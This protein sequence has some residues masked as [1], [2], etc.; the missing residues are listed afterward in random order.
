MS[1]NVRRALADAEHAAAHGQRTRAPANASPAT[2]AL[3]T[4]MLHMWSRGDLPAKTMQELSLLAILDGA[5]NV[6]LAEVA[7]FG[8]FGEYPGN[9]TRDLLTKFCKDLTVCE[10]TL[11]TT[12]FRDPKSS[13]TVEEQMAIFR[14]DLLFHSL[15]GHMEFDAFFGTKE[16]RRFWDLV[17]QSGCPKL[18]DHPLTM[19]PGWKDLTI[20]FWFH[21][22][23]VEYHDRDSLMVFSCGS[24]LGLLSSLDSSLMMAACAK[25]CTVE[26]TATCPGTWAVPWQEFVDAF[27]V[28]AKGI[29]PAV[30]RDGTPHPFAGQRLHPKGYRCFIWVIEGD[31]DFFSNALKLPHWASHKCCWECNTD[32]TNEDTDWHV[33]V[34]PGWTVFTPQHHKERP[35][36]HQIF[37]SP[38]VTTQMIAHDLLHVLFNKGILGHFLG[39]IL[40]LLCF[41]GAR[42]RQ[43]VSPSARLAIVF[44]KIQEFYT[45]ADTDCRTRLTNLR[46]SMF[47]T[48]D[49]PYGRFPSL[50]TK[51]GET[52]HLLPAICWLMSLLDNQTELHQHIIEALIAINKFVLVADQTDWV[53]TTRESERLLKYAE[54][55]LLHYKWLEDWAIG[56]DRKLFHSTIKFHMFHHLAQNARFL[57]PRFCWCFKAEDYVGKI[58]AI[59]ASAVF[60]V[61]S[62]K[63]SLKLMEKYRYML[64]FRLA[65]PLIDG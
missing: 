11:V 30:C 34:N 42:Q 44:D 22:D 41:D 62:T 27:K 1:A 63:L 59:A 19:L 37:D 24:L 58:S 28:L 43:N 47:V 2:S 7:S 48:E 18:Q 8:A 35:S 12:F 14:P 26:P 20:P 10:P 9:C 53:P 23:G 38:G 16:I 64:F 65:R 60:G 29:F 57:G 56:E 33:L 39:S 49:K 32:T 51:G 6:E 17:E 15:A 3:A 50:N 4:K 40:H 54:R 25:T 5:S 13:Q 52:K 61:R 45:R 31:H 46:I 21:G 55:F 36:S